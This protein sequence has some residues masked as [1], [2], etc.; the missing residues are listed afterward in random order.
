M[1]FKGVINTELS[2]HIEGR[3]PKFLGMCIG[4]IWKFVIKT[5]KYGAETTL[6]CTLDDKIECESGKYYSDCQQKPTL[7]AH[8][9]D[10]EQAKKLWELSENLVGLKQ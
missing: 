3:V 4:P 5:P 8:A 7:T 2:R 6:Y 1:W 10:M 9:E